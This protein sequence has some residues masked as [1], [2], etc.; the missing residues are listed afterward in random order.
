MEELQLC[1]KKPCDAASWLTMIDLFSPI[2]SGSPIRINPDL[3][4]P[5]P[6]GFDDDEVLLASSDDESSESPSSSPDRKPV[7]AVAEDDSGGTGGTGIGSHQISDAEGASGFEPDDMV[8]VGESSDKN[9]EV[10][11]SAGED[12]G[13]PAGG[14]QLHTMTVAIDSTISSQ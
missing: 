12:K 14:Q 5:L 2:P 7:T 11:D 6:P 10:V 3:N 8:I 4:H 1:H 13:S 9:D